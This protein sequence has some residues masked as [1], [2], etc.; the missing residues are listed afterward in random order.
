M[1]E[2]KTHEDTVACLQT[3]QPQAAVLIAARTAL[4][5]LPV[6]AADCEPYYRGS[7]LS[8]VFHA[9]AASWFVGT[10]AELEFKTADAAADAVSLA[11]DEKSWAGALASRNAALAVRTAARAAACATA[12]PADRKAVV[13]CAVDTLSAAVRCTGFAACP[14]HALIA[15]GNDLKIARS[16]VVRPNQNFQPLDLSQRP[17]WPGG[18]MPEL[19][20]ELWNKFKRDLSRDQDEE[21]WIAWYE[22]RLAGT[23]ADMKLEKDRLHGEQQQDSDRPDE[24]V[25]SFGY[26]TT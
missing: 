8:S 20:G 18:R 16:G 9:A 21:D 22:A 4:R 24:E 25:Q 1:S 7:A 2:F 23:P 19:M 5:A 15:L 3:F 14:D 6:L 17:L 10:W 12:D 13:G 11:T 26:H